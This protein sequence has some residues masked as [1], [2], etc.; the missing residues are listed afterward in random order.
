[1]ETLFK[2][3]F[4]RSSKNRASLLNEEGR[5]LFLDTPTSPW[6][7]LRFLQGTSGTLGRGHIEKE[8]TIYMLTEWVRILDWSPSHASHMK[9]ILW[10]EFT[11][12]ING[13]DKTCF[14]LFM[15]LLWG[16]HKILNE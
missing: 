13:D 2:L 6:Q 5:A 11:A 9:N 7:L 4:P 3:N 16:S 8:L 14:A 1:M 10:L 15:G 12:S